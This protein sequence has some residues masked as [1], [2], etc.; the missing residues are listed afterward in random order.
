M[1][2]KDLFQNKGLRIIN[3][4]NL[5]VTGTL[6]ESQKEIELLSQ[7][8]TKYVSNTDFSDPKNFARFGSAKMYYE[9]SIKNIYRTYPFDGTSTEKKEWLSGLTDLELHLFEKEYPKTAGHIV[10]NS[11]YSGVSAITSS[12]DIYATKT[13]PQYITIRPSINSY[14]GTGLA[15]HYS[16]NAK[17]TA[18]PLSVY[19]NFGA[20]LEFWIKLGSV[21]QTSQY[22]SILDLWNSSSFGDPSYN[23]L[24]LEYVKNSPNALRLTFLSGSD[25]VARAELLQTSSLNVSLDDWNHIAVSTIS[26]G[27][28]LNVKLYLN[29]NLLQ[30]VLTGSAINGSSK[31][32]I[33]NIGA[34]VYA[35]NQ[36]ANSNGV[37]QGYGLISASF[38]EFRFWKYERSALDVGRNWFTSV[39]GTSNVVQD[40]GFYYKFNEGI[41][42]PAAVNASDSKILDFSGRLID[43]T[44][45][46]YTLSSRNTASAIDLSSL[47]TDLE[48][49]D[50][51]I[52]SVNNTL[53]DFYD[54]KSVSGS[55][56]DD[57]NLRR[58]YKT[59]PTWIL[60][61]EEEAETR[62][63]EQL[64][65]IIASYF[66]DLYNKVADIQ[67]YKNINYNSS[68][69]QPY[70]FYNKVLDSYGFQTSDLFIN[71]SVVE[72]LLSRTDDNVYDQKLYKIKNLIF[73]NIY[74]N[75]IYIYKTK[76]T[77]NSI[78]SL[79]R[80]YGVDEELV[81]INLYADNAEYNLTDTFSETATKTKVINLSKNFEGTIYQSSS[82]SLS[83]IPA[84]AANTYNLNYLTPYTIEAEFIFP[85]KPDLFDNAFVS[86]NFTDV[87]LFGMH[88]AN[89]SSASDYT[90]FSTDPFNFQVYAIKDENNSSNCYFKLLSNGFGRNIQLTSSRYLEAYLN[91]KWNFAVR[92]NPLIDTN[93]NLLENAN[94][95]NNLT[96]SLEFYGVNTISGRKLN[97]F[98]LTSFISGTN[99]INALKSAKRLYVGSH[100]TNFTGSALKYTDVKI[101]S[102]RVWSDYLSDEE[103]IF[104]SKDVKNYG[105]KSPLTKKYFGINNLEN[106]NTLLLNWSFDTITGSDSSGKFIVLDSANSSSDYLPVI[107]N[108]TKYSYDAIGDGV[109]AS[110]TDFIVKEYVQTAKQTLPEMLNGSDMID[111]KGDDDLAFMGNKKPQRSFLS[112]ESNMYQIISEEMINMFA[113]I[114]EFN[115]LIGAISNKYSPEYSDLN[116]LRQLFYKKIGNTPKLEKYLNFYKWLDSSLGL[117]I[118]Q[119]I[120]ASARYN[121]GLSTIVENTIL[122]RDKYEHKLPSQRTRK[123]TNA[124]SVI[125]GI[126]ELQYSWTT[127]SA[128]NNSDASVLT[129][130]TIIGATK[131]ENPEKSILSISIKNIQETTASSYEIREI[132]SSEIRSSFLNKNRPNFKKNYEVIQTSGR[133]VN[134]KSFI[135]ELDNI[136]LQISGANDLAGL[137]KLYPQIPYEPPKIPSKYLFYPFNETITDI[138]KITRNK[139]KSVI[140]NKFGTPGSWNESI[141]TGKTNED[142]RLDFISEEYSLYNTTNYKNLDVRIINNISSSVTMSFSGSNANN[143]R[144]NKNRAVLL[145]Q[146]GSTA[147]R[148]Q[149]DNAYISHQIPRSDSQYNWIT[150]SATS[151]PIVSSFISEIPNLTTYSGSNFS[152]FSGSTTTASLRLNL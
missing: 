1:S 33:G 61:E 37:T 18:I 78:R 136:L 54:E 30:D 43:G 81:K 113:G 111:I 60:E 49:Q 67:K 91:N 68:S 23:R 118:E 64:T 58:L 97:E 123:E 27:S 120:P 10:L 47:T 45:Q 95:Y 137:D 32:L 149:H 52:R 100:K 39:N 76:G 152:L 146:S 145:V 48:P 99:A 142:T 8:K 106:I 128:E 57:E 22:S 9:D 24:L 124:S 21:N 41:I 4:N 114:S 115:T 143:I 80:S 72:E 147:T 125:K 116:Y 138:P 130:T 105:R 38:D 126:E 15:D 109:D 131:L 69:F 46:N 66:D 96:C 98:S 129:K 25:G 11:T 3:S 29:G 71:S 50:P 16:L 77:T 103:I 75:L 55:M 89:S 119:L 12:G 86:A 141:S 44:Y 151:L 112:V 135:S 20:T 122:Q 35:P 70:P 2:L 40:L 5:S 133:D 108:V 121:K 87:S 110:S 73:Q 14:A 6:F 148:N 92:I 82:N 53:V 26:T 7:E 90:W 51:I 93:I 139:T 83:Y 59:F 13:N 132:F 102:A 144:V 56:H 42:D 31:S 140:S 28:N 150:A 134:N 104:H 36:T 63:L 79:L 65:Q 19:G 62:H 34:Y 117:M 88:T 101:L 85:K 94:L 127:S 74:N 17:N 84:I 107:N